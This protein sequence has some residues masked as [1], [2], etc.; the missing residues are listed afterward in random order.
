MPRLSQQGHA[1]ASQMSRHLRPR[2]VVLANQL[3]TVTMGEVN[4]GAHVSAT[5][6]GAASAEER[7][8]RRS[9]APPG[10]GPLPLP[11]PARPPAAQA[12]TA[13]KRPPRT[14]DAVPCRQHRR[15]QVLV[16]G[17]SRR[18]LRSTGVR[19]TDS[20]ARVLARQARTSPVAGARVVGRAVGFRE[21][22]VPKHCA[23]RTRAV[24]RWAMRVVGKP[25]GIRE[26]VRAMRAL[27]LVAA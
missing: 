17:P 21:V 12:P 4:Y 10:V 20:E 6:T 8:S 15:M 1:R 9:A 2:E 27:G 7:D 16:G 19:L 14:G 23:D 18:D 11:S 24:Q 25:A 22:L 3:A 26:C 5:L 13:R